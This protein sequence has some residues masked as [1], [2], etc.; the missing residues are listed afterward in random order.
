MEELSCVTHTH[1]YTGCRLSEYVCVFLVVWER[2][3]VVEL[4]GG[5]L[6]ESIFNMCRIP[7]P[8]RIK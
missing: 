1:T 4:T 6:Y 7:T 8:E 5:E 3:P 2:T